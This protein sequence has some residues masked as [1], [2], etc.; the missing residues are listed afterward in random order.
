SNFSRNIQKFAVTDFNNAP[1]TFKKVKKETWDVETKGLKAIKVNYNYYAAQMDAGGSWL[2]EELLYINFINCMLYVPGKENEACTVDLHI[3]NNYSIACGLSKKEKQLSAKD[4]YQL[5]DS[6][7]IASA[8]LKHMSYEVKGYTFNIWLLGD[9]EPDWTIILDNFKKFTIE[10][11]EMMGD[12]PEKDY[13]FLFQILPYKQHHG[14]EHRNSTSITLGPADQINTK[15][16]Q[17]ELF[18]I[19]CHELY[20]AWNIIKI[21]PAEMLPYDLTKENYFRTGFVAEGVTTY[22]GEYLLARAGVF[23]EED[24]F[25]ELNGVLKKHFENHGRFNLSVADSSFDLW[26]DGY[27][28]GIPNRKV[29]IYGKGALI[30]LIFDIEIRRATNNSKSLDD[31]MVYLYNEFA[32]KD[33][34]YT[35]DDFRKVLETIAG[36]SF[37]ELYNELVFGVAPIESRLD[38][39]FHYIGCELEISEDK[40]NSERIWGMKLVHHGA[41]LIVDY[42]EPGSPADKAL[43]KDDEVLAI[44]GVKANGNLS[45]ITGDKKQLTVTVYRRHKL[46]NLTLYAD[47]KTYLKNYKIVKRKNA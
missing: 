26:V 21:R 16:F 18:S 1:V 17:N 10:Q 44:D 13:H 43:T 28:P 41:K 45:D 7:L 22:Y 27:V 5:V 24:Y 8:S 31:A 30:A 37:K 14:V 25:N 39:A 6:P 23:T 42:T 38:T 29:S 19:S 20:H 40:S 35:I 15:N 3:P 36:T 47:G 2:D 9:C 11:V 34:G 32:K 4:F 33:K 46:L 12:F